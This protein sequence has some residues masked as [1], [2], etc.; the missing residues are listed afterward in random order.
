MIQVLLPEWSDYICQF[1]FQCSGVSLPISADNMNISDKLDVLGNMYDIYD[2]FSAHFRFAC[3]RGCAACCT[4]NVTMTTL[5]GYRIVEHL[6]SSEQPNLP[7]R[8]HP[9]TQQERFQPG[10]TTNQIAA[11]C[12]QRKDPPE[13]SRDWPKA[14]CP[15]LSNNECLVYLHRP[16]GCRCFFSTKKC[17]ATAHAEV[18]PFLITVNMLFMQ[19]IEDIDQGGLFGNMSDVLFFL[20]SDARRNQYERNADLNTPPGLCVNRSVPGLLVPPEHHSRIQP[21][22]EKIQSIRSPRGTVGA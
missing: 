2:T 3:V 5:E 22:L 9:L 18:D 14:P 12:L 16:F 6:L 13:E 15:F 1:R 10:V 21:L 8:L 20:E 17:D 4:Q 19:F 7:Q 11:L